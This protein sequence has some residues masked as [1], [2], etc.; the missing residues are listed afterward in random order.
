MGANATV[1]ARL[2]NWSPVSLIRLKSRHVL[3]ACTETA[4]HSLAFSWLPAQSLDLPKVLCGRT[5]FG[6]TYE[7]TACL[8]LYNALWTVDKALGIAD[9]GS[10]A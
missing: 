2:S 1:T 7:N 9:Y 4:L 10:V 6:A 3:T 8:H 5:E